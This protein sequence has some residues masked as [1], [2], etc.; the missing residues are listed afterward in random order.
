MKADEP[1]LVDLARRKGWHTVFYAAEELAQVPGI[2][3]PSALVQKCV[4][5][6][7]VAEPAALLA[8]GADHLLV[9]KQVIRVSECPH[10][11]TFAQACPPCTSRSNPRTLGKVYFVGAGPGDA[12]LLTLKAYNLLRRAEVVIYAGSLIPEAL[13]RHVPAA[14]KYTTPHASPLRKVLARTLQAVR[15]ARNVVRL[16]SGDTSIY[17]A[18]QEQMAMLEKENVDFEVVPGISSFQALAA[19]LKSEFTLP[20]KVQTIILTRGEGN[21]PMPE[22]ESLELLARHQA[23]IC[24]F[25]SPPGSQGRRKAASRRLSRGHAR[26]HR[27][28]RFLA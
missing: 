10:A 15:S 27:P 23:T 16:Q 25:L 18:I 13:L 14:R 3:T 22:Q 20:E 4:G 21:T 12:Q 1:A 9:D 8:A 2:A 19:A 5:T 17:S 7:G 11:M 26:G 28:P 6:P 24:I